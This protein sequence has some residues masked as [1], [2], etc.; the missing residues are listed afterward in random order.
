MALSKNRL[1]SSYFFS[2]ETRLIER[3]KQLSSVE[4]IRKMVVCRFFQE[5][6]CKFGENCRNEHYI[7]QGEKI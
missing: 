3:L 1:V 7:P 2:L 5:G 4:Q 6:R